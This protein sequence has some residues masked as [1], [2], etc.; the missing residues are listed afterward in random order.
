MEK[1]INILI[2]IKNSP[3]IVPAVKYIKKN[4]PK[5]WMFMKKLILKQKGKQ[6]SCVNINFNNIEIQYM[7][8]QIEKIRK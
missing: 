5:Q 4:F 7:I 3:I 8:S 1:I 6:A 2:N